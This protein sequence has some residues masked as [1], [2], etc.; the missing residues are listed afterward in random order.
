MSQMDQLIAEL[1]PRGVEHK[2]LGDVGVFARGNGLQKKDLTESGIGAIHYGQLY[3]HYG[4]WATETKSFV[5]PELAK[6]LRRARVGDLVIATTSE[7]DA[8]VCKAVAW[9]G[10]ADIA[11]SGD[12]YIYRHMLEPK[13]V[14]YFFQSEQ[15]RA[16]KMHHITGAKVK[17]ISGESMAKF[18]IPVPPLEVQREIV[19]VLDAFTNLEAELEAELEARRRQYQYYRDALLAFSDQDVRWATMA[20]VGKFIRGRR[21]TKA[22]YAEK[23]VACIHYGEIYTHYGTSAN[24]VI[25]H[26]RAEMKATLRFAKPGDVVI[27]DVGETVEDVGKAVA[28]IGTEDV[29]IHDHCY[30]FRHSMNPRFVSYCMQTTS[31]I[32]EKAK[33]VARTKVNTLL[34]DGFSKIHIPVPPL[35]VQERIVDILDKFDAMVND[36]SNGLP[37]EIKARRQQYAHYRDRL[38]SFRE[39]A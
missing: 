36:L 22:D 26:V 13:Y 11:I 25:S 33:Y 29:A 35:D 32:A 2:T 37:A 3:T 24:K 27:T 30:A 17:R 21:F 4:V 39:A 16:Q 34:M 9:L 1:C 10:E 8:D 18:R 5:S 15:F 19:K 31:F 7:N 14:A 38:L 23:G 28:W 6:K 20:E 12:A